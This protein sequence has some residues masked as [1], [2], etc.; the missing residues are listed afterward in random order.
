MAFR[1]SSLLRISAVWR[2]YPFQLEVVECRDDRAKRQRQEESVDHA[3]KNF[4]GS[5]G[6]LK[7]RADIESVKQDVGEGDDQFPWHDCHS[8]IGDIAGFL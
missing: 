1:S 4:S 5:D 8:A 3:E 7:Y 2:W 6:V